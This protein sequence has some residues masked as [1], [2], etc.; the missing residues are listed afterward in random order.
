[1]PIGD[2]IIVELPTKNGMHLLTKPFDRRAFMLK[3]PSVDLHRDSPINLFI[4]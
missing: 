4:P 1:M 2:K 3:Y